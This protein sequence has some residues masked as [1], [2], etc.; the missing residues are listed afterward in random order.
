M[1]ESSDMLSWCNYSSG[2]C[3]ESP[4]CSPKHCA[5]VLLDH[6]SWVVNQDF[7]RCSA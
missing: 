2:P 3:M 4:Y 1:S 7:T 6:L 5:R